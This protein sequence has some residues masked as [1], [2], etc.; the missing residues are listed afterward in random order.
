MYEHMIDGGT[1][2]KLWI[3][4]APLY[5][6]HLLR[7]DPESRR[8][9]FGGAVADEF[10]HAYGQPG[11]LAGAVIHGFFVDGVLR[12]AAELRTLAIAHE[13]EVA[14]SVE[15]AWQSF[16]VGTA[17]LERILL[18]AR[19]RGIRVLH[20]TCLAENPRMR[21]LALKFHADL[22]L[23]HASVVG[24]VEAPSATPM[25]LALE[26][27]IDST[28]FATAFLDLQAQLLRAA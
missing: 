4:Q 26:L 23:D 27:V 12:A 28:G 20:M 13:A 10:I 6:E 14:L 15:K 16:G 3:N 24:E 22:K 18:A 25:S 2:R 11:R 17:L 19:N 8:N 1:I 7:L 21:Q 9:R 5:R